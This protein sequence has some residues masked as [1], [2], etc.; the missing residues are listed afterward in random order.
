LYQLPRLILALKGWRFCDAT[1]KIKNA[2]EEL[3]IVSQNDFQEFFQH[4]HSRWQNFN[5]C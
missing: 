4:L 5:S 3:K 2:T 1:D